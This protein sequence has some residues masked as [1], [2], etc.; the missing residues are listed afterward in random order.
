MHAQA[1]DTG[2]FSLRDVGPALVIAPHDGVRRPGGSVTAVA[3]WE[4]QGT[5]SPPRNRCGVRWLKLWHVDKEWRRYPAL[6]STVGQSIS[7]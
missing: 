6:Y 2:Y 4:A 5:N 7:R 3:A 1:F